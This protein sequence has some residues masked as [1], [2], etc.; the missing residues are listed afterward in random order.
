MM[1]A[2]NSLT[3][4]M[5]DYYDGIPWIDITIIDTLADVDAAMAAVNL[6]R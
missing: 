3:K 2:L 1:T 5:S 4:V 6:V